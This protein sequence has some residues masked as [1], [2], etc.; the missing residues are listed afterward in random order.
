M[1][2]ILVDQEDGAQD[3]QISDII[4]TEQL[5]F[6]S[7]NKVLMKECYEKNNLLL[8]RITNIDTKVAAR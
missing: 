5:D 7:S 3:L 1:T 6:Q 2:V 4:A 8:L